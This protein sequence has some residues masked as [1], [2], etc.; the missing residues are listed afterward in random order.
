M[1]AN[2]KCDKERPRNFES[3]SLLTSKSFVRAQ[4]NGQ[5]WLSIPPCKMSIKTGSITVREER[6]RE[7][8]NNVVSTNFKLATIR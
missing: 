7:G 4:K 5:T 1:K 3:T 2:Q 8:E 6:G